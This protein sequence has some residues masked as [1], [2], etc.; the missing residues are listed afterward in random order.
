ERE[1][2]YYRNCLKEECTKSE[3]MQ[4]SLTDEWYFVKK[5]LYNF[6]T[7]TGAMTAAQARESPLLKNIVRFDQKI[8][9]LNSSPDKNVKTSDMQEIP[10]KKKY[11]GL[12]KDRLP[13]QEL[14]RSEDMGE[15]TLKEL[16][17]LW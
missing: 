16:L 15:A 5:E 17:N 3:D 2:S 10:V 8:A 11:T 12:L 9:E 7:F 4:N 14:K 6:I 1:V 13:E